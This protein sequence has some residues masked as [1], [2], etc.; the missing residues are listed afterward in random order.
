MRYYVGVINS[1]PVVIISSVRK[2][3]LTALK[4]RWL[5]VCTYISIS[6]SITEG[7]IHGT[8]KQRS[9]VK[10]R[11]YPTHQTF[12]SLFTMEQTVHIQPILKEQIQHFL[13]NVEKWTTAWWKRRMGVLR[14]P[15]TNRR[16]GP[17]LPGEEGTRDGSLAPPRGSIAQWSHVES[18]LGFFTVWYTDLRSWLSCEIWLFFR[19]SLQQKKGRPV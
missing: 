16:S 4:K 17:H 7:F 10:I 15:A 18:F 5:S 11:C 2:G 6:V 1:A 19:P 12:V 3:F 9:S 14:R 13:L 8:H